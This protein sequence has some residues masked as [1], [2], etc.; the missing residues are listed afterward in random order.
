MS[1]DLELLPN[2]DEP[3]HF[4]WG[5]S[6]GQ[7]IDFIAVDAGR[8]DNPGPTVVMHELRGLLTSDHL[9]LRTCLNCGKISGLSGKRAAPAIL[10][11]YW[12]P[13]QHESNVF[14]ERMHEQ[15][16]SVHDLSS[17]QDAVVHAGKHVKR[18]TL[19]YRDSCDLRVLCR[20]R[21]AVTDP[22]IRAQMTMQV[23]KLRKIERKQ[24]QEQ[25]IADAAHMNWGANQALLNDDRAR[26]V[27]RLPNSLSTPLDID[28]KERDMSKWP[29]LFSQFAISIF[30][31]TSICLA[32]ARN[33]LDRLRRSLQGA[34]SN[35]TLD[36]LSI[37]P[38]INLEI[39]LCALDALKRGKAV[40]SDGIV[41]EALMIPSAASVDQFRPIAIIDVVM[42]LY[43]RFDMVS[44]D[45]VWDLLQACD[46]PER[47]QFAIMQELL[48]GRKINPNVFGQDCPDVDMERGVRQGSP[49]SAL[50][51]S[52]I[53]NHMLVKRSSKWKGEGKGLFFGEFG[54]V[55]GITEAWVA[56]H[57]HL[58]HGFSIQDLFVSCLAFADDVYILA[59][60][61]SEAE[62][63]LADL[64][65]ELA[66]LGLEIQAKKT[67]WMANKFARISELRVCDVSV[68]VSVS[69]VVLGCLVRMDSNELDTYE[70]R[71]VQAWNCFHKWRLRTTQIMMLRLMISCKKRS[72]NDVPEPRKSKHAASRAGNAA[73]R[74]AQAG[75]AATELVE[76]SFQVRAAR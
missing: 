11:K 26:Q 33:K 34:F 66:K 60:S 24:W 42:N 1:N 76:F 37:C 16:N 20:K 13:D 39:L 15:L 40:G 4:P 19:R 18:K 41:A 31:W 47:L 29:L 61:T 71:I 44:L 62:A 55:T 53:I 45:A 21:N 30:T 38:L 57:G 36:G 27:I 6:V 63:M 9:P 32:T 48:D 49:E 7:Q 43:M 23:A 10:H 68:D 12:K 69:L 46:A 64:I 58:F 35:H 72:V 5:Q 14:H 59:K 2:P 75:R 65:I 22:N 8:R 74:R 25:M 52:A 50:F 51:F 56:M 54:G 28:I 3:T 70:H 73:G 17:F 67:K